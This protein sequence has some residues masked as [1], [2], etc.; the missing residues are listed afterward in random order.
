MT[1]ARV[2]FWR[3]IYFFSKGSYAM[4]NRNT[5]PCRKQAAFMITPTELLMITSTE[6]NSQQTTHGVLCLCHSH[7]GEYLARH[8]RKWHHRLNSMEGKGSNQ[9]YSKFPFHLLSLR[10]ALS[11]FD[12]SNICAKVPGE[13]RYTLRGKNIYTSGYRQISPY[14]SLL[15]MVAPLHILRFEA[16]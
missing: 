15:Y 6:S 14:G 11:S 9:H 5:N 12:G 13:E 16:S 4:H 8:K 10:T 2:T 1:N 3:R 7:T